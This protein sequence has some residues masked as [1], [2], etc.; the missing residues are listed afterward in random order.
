MRRGRAQRMYRR[1]LH[2]VLNDVVDDVRGVENTK[3][4]RATAEASS[5]SDDSSRQKKPRNKRRRLSDCPFVEHEAG[6][7]HGRRRGGRSDRSEPCE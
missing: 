7:S 2:G 5:A 1:G 3:A 4:L 6:V